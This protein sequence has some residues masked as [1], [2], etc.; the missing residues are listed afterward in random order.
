MGSEIP[1]FSGIIVPHHVF[2]KP[3]LSDC[4]L[5]IISKWQTV[6]HHFDETWKNKKTIMID[7]KKIKA[8]YLIL[9]LSFLFNS[10]SGQISESIQVKIT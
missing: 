3:K 2:V 5:L 10:C 1:K 4:E 9:I 7:C 6:V 8:N